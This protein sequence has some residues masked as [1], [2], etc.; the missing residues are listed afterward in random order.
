MLLN[1][2]NASFDNFSI[3]LK[4]SN[5]CKLQLKESL[6]MSRDKPILNKNIYSIPLELFD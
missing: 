4:E 3:I 2:H 5:A 6:L 1:G